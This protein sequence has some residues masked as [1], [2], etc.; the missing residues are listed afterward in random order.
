MQNYNCKNCGAVL[1]W[2]PKASSLKCAF[3]GKEHQPSDFEDKTLDAK[4]VK[5]ES[6]EKK[7]ASQEVTEDMVIYECK[8]CGGEVVTLKTTMATV[9]PY[10]GEAISITSKSV[11]S[12]RP[13]LIVPFSKTKE[14]IKKEYNDYVLKS[15]LTPKKF[16]KQHI[17]EKIQ[18][19]YVPFLL[20]DIDN[21]SFF[22][23]N[24]ELTSNYRSGN[25]RV[26]VHDVYDL[27]ITAEGQYEKIPTDGSKRIDDFL[28]ES[29]EPF[30]YEN[31]NAY[32]PAYMAGF[33][34]EQIDDDEEQLKKRAVERATI[35]MENN[36]KRRFSNYQALVKKNELFKLTNYKTKYVMLPV[37]ILN[38]N[39]H[40]KKYT[41]AVNGQTGKVVGKLPVDKLKLILVAFGTAISTGLLMPAIFALTSML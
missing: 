12:F 40:N 16:K 8:T 14:E 31:L 5:D 34:A 10:C 7:Y 32:D 37:W 38:V 23:F 11:G 3:C 35:G 20:H 6:V 1:S 29:L 26:T 19:I 36:A 25:D 2:D 41:F 27:S 28:M 13:E 30:M 17:I 4:F 18:G 24:G 9:C 39:Y 33:V 22:E 15:F 21:Q